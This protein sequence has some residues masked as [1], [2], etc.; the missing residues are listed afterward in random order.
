MLKRDLQ[1]ECDELPK[2]KILTHMRD[3]NV[4]A[5]TKQQLQ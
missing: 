3:R 4:T 1:S 5:A 2:E